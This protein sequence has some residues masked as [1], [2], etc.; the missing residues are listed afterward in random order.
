MWIVTPTGAV[1]VVHD[2]V[3]KCGGF[4]QGLA[5]LPEDKSQGVCL[6]QLCTKYRQGIAT[7]CPYH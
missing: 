7:L 6:V 2:L 5:S 4:S 3:D 1:L